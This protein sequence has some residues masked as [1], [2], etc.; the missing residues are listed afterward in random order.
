MGGLPYCEI[1][2]KSDIRAEKVYLAWAAIELIIEATQDRSSEEYLK[3]GKRPKNNLDV[4]A[5]KSYFV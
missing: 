5:T 3:D 4:L 2:V 1:F